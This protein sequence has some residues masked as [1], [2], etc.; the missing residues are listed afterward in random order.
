MLRI[1]S[2]KK[3]PNEMSA[4]FHT[5]MPAADQPTNHLTGIRSSPAG[6]ETMVRI[7]DHADDRQSAPML[8]VD[9]FMAFTHET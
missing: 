1:F 8:C 9:K 7:R 3:Y 5:A 4:V 2:L 6:M